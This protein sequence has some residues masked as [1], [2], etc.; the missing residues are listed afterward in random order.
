MNTN[1]QFTNLNDINGAKRSSIEAKINQLSRYYDRLISVEAHL[2]VEN[3][4]HTVTL[5]AHLPRTKFLK[6][7]SSDRSL[8]AALSDALDALQQQLIRHKQRTDEHVIARKSRA[9]R[10]ET[11]DFE[12]E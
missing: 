12:V 11:L 3:H 6:A 8:D 4:D 1:I 2:G 9:S 10:D 5:V 7:E